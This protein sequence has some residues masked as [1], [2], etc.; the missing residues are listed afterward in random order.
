MADKK[1]SE[2]PILGFSPINTT[3]DITAS[4]VG[5]YPQ[6]IVP[7][8]V[9]GTT[10][11]ISLQNFSRYVTQYNATTGSNT[12][13][14]NQTVQGNVTT[15]GNL[16]V[17]GKLT[18]QEVHTEITSASIIFE[19]GSTIFG[20]SG[21][22]T[23][24]FTG[25]VSINGITIGAQAVNDFT[26]ST[27]AQL[28]RVYQTTSS[29]N[30][31]TG[32]QD[33]R[34]FVISEFTSSTDAH[35]VGI[36]TY[37]SSL[38]AQLRRV[39][40]TTSSLNIF[41]GSQ[42]SRNFVISQFTA[43][44]DAHI[45]GIS[46]Y[47][48]SL[49]A[50]LRRVYQTT[51][52]LNIFTGSQD[53]R[54][55]VISQ[56]TSSTDAH[57]VGISD[58]TSSQL[59]VNLGNSVYTSSLESHLRRVYQT[60]SSLNI[61]TG[62]QDSRNFVIS[63]FTAST[64]NHILGISDFT[65]SINA[66]IVNA[67]AVTASI[68]A[69]L[70]RVYQTTS[71]LNI[72]TGSQDSRNL[73]ISQF[74]SSTDAH[75]VGIS[76]FTSSQLAVNLG[77]SIFTS[78]ARIELNS[79]E[80]YTASLKSAISV[81]GNNVQIIG[82]LN[83][84]KLNVQ[85]IS[86]S[87]LVTSG[88][89]VFGDQSTDK[90]EFTGSVYLQN[91]LLLGTEVLGNAGLN[92]ITA[93]TRIELNSIEEY[94]A[95]LK[96]A[97]IVSS[98]TQIQN[99]DLFA[100]N[101][102]L[103]TATGSL[104]AQLNGVEAYTA[105]LKAA[106]IVSSSTQIVNYNLFALTAS[107]NT[108]YGT[109]SITGSVRI[110]GSI[111]D[112]KYI[113]FDTVEPATGIARLGWDAGEGTLTIG[114]SGGNVNI[115][116]GVTNFETAYNAD[117]SSIS[118]GDVVRVSGAQGN[119]VAVQKANNLNDDGSATTVALAAETIGVG[120]EGK[121]I[122]S[123]LLKGINTTAFGE[124]D[125]LYLSSTP[126]GITNIKPHAPFHEVRIG[127][128]QR[129]HASV[130]IVNVKVDNGYEIDELHNVLIHTASLADKQLLAYSGSVWANQTISNLG[131]AETAS[132]NPVLA[133][134]ASLKAAAIVS[135]SQQIT[136]YYKFAETASAN[137]FYGTQT[138][139]NAETTFNY[140]PQTSI[141]AGYNYLNFG[142]GS[143]MY[144][145]APDIYIGSNAKYGSAGTV[146]ANYTSANGMGLLTMDGASLRYQATDVSVTAGNAYGVPIRF[147]ING[148][149]N[150][151]VNTTAPVASFLTGSLT[152]RKSYNNDIASVPTTTAQSYYSNQSG[153]YLFGR[154]S[155]ISIIGANSEEATICYGNASTNRFASISVGTGTNAVGGDLYIKVGSDTE[156]LR[157]AATGDGNVTVSTGNLVIGTSGKGIDF[158]ATSNS[159][160]T[161]TSE[162]LNDYEEG[163][164]T[165]V[166]TDLTND[167][168]MDGTYTRG[169][170]TKIGRQVTV[171]GYILTTS[172][173]SVTGNVKIK[174]LP[175]TNGSG[176]GS[177][178][179]GSI[180]TASGLNITA[181]HSVHIS[182]PLGQN[183]LGLS[184]GDDATGTTEMTAAE[185]SADGQIQ[186]LATY[187]VD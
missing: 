95:S 154:N 112:I 39:Y 98:S 45:V 170:Y 133:Y 111:D 108:F 37:T 149:G 181:G 137:T 17:Q 155:G 178:G 68:F 31:F 8:V 136:N 159:S 12:F 183:H 79:I 14:G 157:I 1:I 125:L 186:M 172:L 21:D 92:A 32:S 2:L 57:I 109:Q 147:A 62:S 33:N 87:V 134:T 175:F 84:N 71:S 176:F 163:N 43:S 131:I 70:E 56:F 158:S 42:D 18:A 19:S 132:L 148:D 106:A 97:A 123:G 129:I 141:L 105:S 7:V 3:G 6:N 24:Q 80:A 122:T 113:D 76:A 13:I 117:S 116:I 169:T 53:S 64:D 58:F 120:A 66:S 15:T 138:F 156:R 104:Q 187:F 48:S 52:S 50:Q 23:H 72:F 25:V 54:N 139:V 171:R 100:L 83:V 94:T 78:S 127:V 166:I 74:T 60:T 118:K 30:I 160:G 107:A 10:Y 73:T 41:T 51:S 96:T 28:R 184:V 69:Q 101:S 77:N 90:H 61:F 102:N 26:A 29:L 22:D 126:G 103:Y 162:L 130:G 46:T 82:D 180:G 35:I 151:G 81:S 40:Q 177:L 143:I 119:R 182:T 153:L 9:G 152:I 114:L 88:S 4:G 89:N 20:N 135:S 168:S 124:G 165:P 44:T 161:M 75:I 179:G 47:T 121:V 144:R 63:Q 91:S 59:N 174:G 150:V 34:N 185:W 167:A 11:Q 99:Y 67:S 142:G 85:Y 55:F 146:V 115:P 164:W 140:N 86:S 5:V 49:E 128:A 110:S 65:A 36:S 16:I 93:S 27:D 38:E 173:G 145:N